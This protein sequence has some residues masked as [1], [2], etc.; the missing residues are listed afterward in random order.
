MAFNGEPETAFATACSTV[1]AVNTLVDRPRH[2]AIVKGL[3]RYL[4]WHCELVM[5]SQLVMTVGFRTLRR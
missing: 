3:N 2:V 5:H 4:N 1:Q